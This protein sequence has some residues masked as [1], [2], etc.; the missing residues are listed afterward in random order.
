MSI[1]VRTAPDASADAPYDVQ[2]PKIAKRLRNYIGKV[3]P[4]A[5]GHYRLPRPLQGIVL[6]AGMSGEDVFE[7]CRDPQT[8]HPFT[9][10]A[11]DPVKLRRVI[12]DYAE[13]AI[14][15]H[16]TA[17]IDEPFLL[18]LGDTRASL[19]VPGFSKTRALWQP[20]NALLLPLRQRRHFG[21]IDRVARADMA[22]DEKERRLVWRGSTTDNFQRRAR[23]PHLGSR[24]HI[25]D[26][27]DRADPVRFD[28]GYSSITVKPGQSERAV[29][30]IAQY[31]K[32]P[33]ALE[34]QLAYRYILCL[35]GN[36]VSS[37]LKWGLYSNSVVLMPHPQVESW[38]CESFLE[39]YVHFVPVKA[40]LS[41]LEA[42]VDWCDANEDAC[43]EIAEEGRRFISGFLDDA[44]ETFL[45]VEV[46]KAYHDRV[47]LRVPKAS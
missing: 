32:A 8:A 44:L 29:E 34:E 5:K 42:Q 1:E 21:R 33:V 41:D 36:D 39:P 10:L 7:M 38:A 43:R 47:R 20:G 26:V 25:M 16:R 6:H 30:E 40:D 2:D 15:W 46:V 11:A 13:P 9:Q 3:R 4:L 27:S 22:F 31:A 18:V 24:C 19:S 37:G 28:V 12:Q 17:G 35:E 23:R 14:G 45:A